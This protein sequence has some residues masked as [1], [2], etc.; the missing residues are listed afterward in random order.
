MK[1]NI[2][3]FSII[4]ILGF[5]LNLFAQQKFMIG[6]FHEPF[7]KKFDDSVTANYRNEFIRWKNS[8]IN[9]SQSQ[10]LYWY[11]PNEYLYLFNKVLK[12]IN[13]DLDVFIT[14]QHFSNKSVAYNQSILSSYI[15]G[16]QNYASIINL[17]DEPKSLDEIKNVLNTNNFV[18]KNYPNCKTFVNLLPKISF[19]KISDYQSYLE[20]FKNIDLVAFDYYLPSY[21]DNND[22]FISL[23]NMQKVFGKK[24]F[25]SYVAINNGG[26]LKPPKTSEFRKA[27][28]SSLAYGAKGII[29]FDKI[30]SNSPPEL[31][32][33]MPKINKYITKVV[34]PVILGSSSCITLH[35]YYT[36][37]DEDDLNS[38]IAGYNKSNSDFIIQ[39]IGNN[40][41]LVSQFTIKDDLNLSKQGL[42]LG[43]KYLLIVNKSLTKQKGVQITLNGNYDGS[44]Y[45]APRYMNFNENLP[46]N[47][48]KS[49]ITNT[50]GLSTFT[51]SEIEGGEGILIKIA[52][53]AVPPR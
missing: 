19:S 33:E 2:K 35:Q 50:S 51:I 30:L 40:Q 27:I 28:F 24:S 21:G 47:F 29:Y 42:M 52:S 9:F 26:G 43:D 11:N 53:S 1:K 13:Y 20:N 36:K 37:N 17:G 3:I 41:I 45:S 38:T 14:S 7:F 5:N 8:G 34:G 49:S 23:I 25:L 39:S 4:L 15:N 31:N 46:V 44:V 48:E 22:F 16:L 18:Q 6:V 12:P 32:S 10:I